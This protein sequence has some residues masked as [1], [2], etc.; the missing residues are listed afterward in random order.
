MQAKL[1]FCGAAANG[2][3]VGAGIFAKKS[4]QS[5]NRLR[6]YTSVR[7]MAFIHGHP[8]NKQEL[9]MFMAMVFE[10]KSKNPGLILP[11]I[12]LLISLLYMISFHGMWK[13]I[14]QSTTFCRISTIMN[15]WC[16]RL[17]PRLWEKIPMTPIPYPCSGKNKQQHNNFEDPT[18]VGLKSFRTRTSCT[19]FFADQVVSGLQCCVPIE[20]S[21]SF[22]E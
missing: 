19:K 9:C 20:F 16:K 11:R 22:L 5:N 10:E 6:F 3:L 8:V 21:I 12:H 14:E 18:K 2:A 17:W 1:S 13:L 7:R 15:I 4:L